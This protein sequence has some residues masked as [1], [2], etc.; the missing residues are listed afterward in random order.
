MSFAE[1]LKQVRKM[2]Q[3]T[4]EELAEQLEVSRQAVSK[5]ESS[6]GHPETETLLKIS[7][8]FHVSLDVLMSDEAIEPNSSSAPFC[9]GKITIE[10]YDHK[11]FITCANVVCTKLFR[12]KKRER[13]ANYALFGITGSGIWGGNYTLIALY[14]DK[15]QADQEI[16]AIMQAMKEGKAIYQI[17]YGNEVKQVAGKF[18]IVS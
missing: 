14:K 13:Y 11:G 9:S 18:Q 17:Q 10:A 2:H 7:R 16:S 4:Q 1:Q 8:M 12:K 3:L 6:A 15:T 5:W